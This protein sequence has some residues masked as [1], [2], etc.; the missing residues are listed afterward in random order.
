MRMSI[1]NVRTETFLFCR[2][3]ICLSRPR[4]IIRVV[5]PVLSELTGWL[6][7][8]DFVNTQVFWLAVANL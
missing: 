2:N 7:M 1:A 3:E 4:R 8:D 6:A 5:G